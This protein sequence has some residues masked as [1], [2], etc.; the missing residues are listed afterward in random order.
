MNMFAAALVVVNSRGGRREREKVCSRCRG[1]CV[2]RGLFIPNHNTHVLCAFTP[3][4]FA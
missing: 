3:G 4:A 1:M 2:T